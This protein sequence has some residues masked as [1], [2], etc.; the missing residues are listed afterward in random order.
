MDQNQNQG[1]IA[2]GLGLATAVIPTVILFM[3]LNVLFWMPLAV[4][5]LLVILGIRSILNDSWLSQRIGWIALVCMILVVGG[6]FCLTWYA[7][8]S[9]PDVVI[10]VPN[11]F[12][13]PLKLS[14]DPKN[15]TEIPMEG[16]RFIVRIPASGHLV[17]K[18]ADPFTQWHSET[19]MFEN[20][21]SLSTNHDERLPPEK[22]RLIDLGSSL[23]RSG[24]SSDE[25]LN[26]FVGNEFDFR[27]FK[28]G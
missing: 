25:S 3:M 27:L 17:I 18:N 7:N 8:R 14:L 28:K 9:G 24:H 16:S 2:V 5:L 12:R 6:T 11:G 1:V 13:G 20:G 10:I 4:G 15:G 21:E 26:Y 23:S 19:A 22:V